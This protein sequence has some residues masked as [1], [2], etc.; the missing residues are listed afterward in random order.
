MENHLPGDCLSFLTLS[1][2]CY[3]KK[4]L[5]QTYEVYEL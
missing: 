5:D 3:M 1:G 4:I 2:N